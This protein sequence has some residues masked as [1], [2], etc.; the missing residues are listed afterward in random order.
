[1]ETWRRSLIQA[2]QKKSAA[3]GVRMTSE[4]K[5][6]GTHGRLISLLPFSEFIAGR[7]IVIGLLSCGL[8]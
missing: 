5:L 8:P 7:E 1:M 6:L 3:L 4:T 2:D